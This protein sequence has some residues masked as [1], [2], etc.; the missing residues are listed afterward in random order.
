MSGPGSHTSPAC[1]PEAGAG[2]PPVP[3]SAPGMAL[4]LKP[5]PDQAAAAHRAPADPEI[6]RRVEAA[7]T[8]L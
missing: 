6:L 3:V 4:P 1:P 2:P 8:R 7:L 5:R